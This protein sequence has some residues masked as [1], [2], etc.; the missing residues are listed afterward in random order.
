MYSQ[1]DR[2]DAL[3][4]NTPS[5]APPRRCHRAMPAGAQLTSRL[6]TE[7]IYTARVCFGSPTVPFDLVVDTG[8][9]LTTVPCTWCSHCGRHLGGTGRQYDPSRSAT[10]QLS[11][12]RPGVQLATIANSTSARHR[13]CR[14]FETSYAESS[15][16]HG[17]LVSDLTYAAPANGGGVV[18]SMRARFGCITHET[19]MLY[20]QQADGLLGLAQMSGSGRP[21]ILDALTDPQLPQQQRRSKNFSLPQQQPAPQRRG[22]AYKSFSFCLSEGGGRLLLGG[23]AT[24]GRLAARGAIVV[25]LLRSANSIGYRVPLH[26]LRVEQ[27]LGSKVVD[28]AAEHSR[29]FVQLRPAAPAAAAAAAT[30]NG[31]RYRHRSGC[32]IDSGSTRMK[33]PSPMFAAVLGVLRRRVGAVGRLELAASGSSSACAY[34]TNAT[35][36][37]LPRLALYLGEATRPLVIAPQQYMMHKPL[38]LRTSVLHSVARFAWRGGSPPAASHRMCSAIDD[39]GSASD[40]VLGAAAL[41]NT[42]VVITDDESVAFASEVDCDRAVEPPILVGSVSLTC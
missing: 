30:G 28:P 2:Y 20:A 33:L 23:T 24:S 15:A 10:L 37:A 26:E 17:L 34:L 40:I 14:A 31:S 29:T 21:S 41:R 4:V 38:V 1:C 39:A 16:Y 13:A 11:E 19:G 7:G 5:S 22:R 9:F 42:E 12:C 27:Q 18:K 35:L 6:A 36:D 25:P 3:A 8:S 32:L